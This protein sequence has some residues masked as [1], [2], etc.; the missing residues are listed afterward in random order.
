MVLVA[1]NAPYHHKRKIGSLASLSKKQ[2]IEL[3]VKHEVE[4]IELPM[5]DI[6]M[7][8]LETLDE[9]SRNEIDRGETIQIDFDPHL[10]SER[11]GRNPFIGN[12]DELKVS[13]VNYLREEK[14]ELLACKV[15]S[16]LRERGHEILWT[17]PY[18]PDLQPIELFWATG[19][20]HVAKWYFKGRSMKDTVQLLRDGWYGTF[21][22]F[23]ASDSKRKTPVDCRKLVARS[24]DM[25]N[26]KFVPRCEGISGLIGSLEIS[27]I[28][29]DDQV[30]FPIDALVVDLTKEDTEAVDLTAD[31]IVGG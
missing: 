7:Q 14:P 4:W 6:Q 8:H 17:P 5:N 27:E 25:A 22:R 28:E 13:F 2:V 19:K 30:V 23:G 16:V 12:C 3:M 21:N 18:C 1:D 9:D 10:Q 11:A 24:I 29:Q 20:N 26:K 15:E 31:T